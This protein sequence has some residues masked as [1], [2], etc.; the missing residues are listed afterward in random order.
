MKH[1]TYTKF[2]QNNN[3]TP[4]ITPATFSARKNTA[5]DSQA[6][7]LFYQPSYI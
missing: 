5:E 7:K 1:T 2:S 4:H 3:I 6:Q